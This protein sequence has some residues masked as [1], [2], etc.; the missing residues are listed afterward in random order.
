M[1]STAAVELENV[2]TKGAPK[3][4]RDPL[5]FAVATVGL[6]L[7]AAA[8]G[9][10]VDA[11]KCVGHD[12][13]PPT[14][15]AEYEATAGFHYLY[16]E[17]TTAGLHMPTPVLRDL[18]RRRSLTFSGHT[19]VSATLS[20]PNSL[21]FPLAQSSDGMRACPSPLAIP[22]PLTSLTVPAHVRSPPP[23]AR[24]QICALPAGSRTLTRPPRTAAAAARLNRPGGL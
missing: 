11:E 1:A 6:V 15:F 3:P 12:T 16:G 19:A 18:V 8:L 20:R 10:S 21:G 22:C 24:R 4:A 17:S 5:A 9:L 2:T 23:R 13:L 14:L 7:A